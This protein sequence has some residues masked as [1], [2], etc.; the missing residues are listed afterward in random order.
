MPHL[1]A[2]QGWNKGGGA[3]VSATVNKALVLLI[4]ALFDVGAGLE[5]T[6]G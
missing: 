1:R 5:G 4:L 3:I 6:G 2:Q